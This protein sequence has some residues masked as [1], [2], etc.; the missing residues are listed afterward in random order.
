M[1]RSQTLSLSNIPSEHSTL[2]GGGE[3][4][5]CSPALTW[6]QWDLT[7]EGSEPTLP[8]DKRAHL[9]ILWGDIPDLDQEN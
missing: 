1:W 4:Y 7:Q 8:L 9:E 6:D 5:F 2:Q 3:W